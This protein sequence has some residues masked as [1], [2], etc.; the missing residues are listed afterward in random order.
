MEQSHADWVDRYIHGM[1]SARYQC[2]DSYVGDVDE[3]LSLSCN[4][5]R[6]ITEFEHSPVPNELLE[7]VRGPHRELLTSNRD[8]MCKALVDAFE[9]IQERSQGNVET[10]LIAPRD[11]NGEVAKV[12]EIIARG[13]GKKTLVTITRAIKDGVLVHVKMAVDA[14]EVSEGFV[15]CYMPGVLA[16]VHFLSRIYRC[17]T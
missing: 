15:T 5:A 7:E 6:G 16:L 12:K 9:F 10:G 3:L 4:A 13:Q 2:H 17:R 14:W 1:E 8:N 11:S